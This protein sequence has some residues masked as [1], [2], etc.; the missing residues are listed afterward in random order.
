VDTAST[1]IPPHIRPDQVFDFNIWTDEAAKHDLHAAYRRLHRDAPDVFYTAANGGHW[2]V[3]RHDLVA[4]LHRDVENFSNAQMSVPKVDTPYRMIPLN[5]DPPDHMPFRMVLMRYL[6][7]GAIAALEPK[8][9][10][11]AGK[12]IDSVVVDG[13][14]E[15]VESVGAAFPVSVF[16]ELMG[17]PLERFHEFRSVVV[18]YFSSITAE[19]RIELEAFVC[20]ETSKPIGA[21]RPPPQND[22]ISS[23]TAEEVFG[24]KLTMEELQSICFLLFVAGLD[25]VAN[26]LSFMF[27]HL[28]RDRALQTR[29]AGAD[30][31]VIREFVEETLRCFAIVNGGRMVKK[32]VDFHGAL[33]KPGDMVVTMLTIAGLDDR[34]T[35]DPER[36]DIDRPKKL[37]YAFATGPHT[38]AGHY[39]ARAEMRIFVEEWL[40]RIPSFSL[41]THSILEFRSGHVNAVKAV[42]LRWPTAA[43]LP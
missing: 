6:S 40:K 36:F 39:L 28:A 4:E 34:M 42:E 20:G 26:S 1:M 35:V 22:L 10:E 31:K 11:W 5:L 43:P 12:L 38:C 19:R 2:V 25:T 30:T 9:R 17:L 8:I 14:C 41:D 23:L 27:L 15:F 21:R 24:R 37:H 18:E 29:L 16:M 13:K 7:G 32:E 33:F 3:T